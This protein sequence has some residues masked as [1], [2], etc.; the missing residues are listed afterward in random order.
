LQGSPLSEEDKRR[1][2]IFYE[3]ESRAV[4]SLAIL[5]ALK[6]R[7]AKVN[8]DDIAYAERIKRGQ[9]ARGYQILLTLVLTLSVAE[10]GLIGTQLLGALSILGGVAE[11]AMSAGILV[12]GIILVIRR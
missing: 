10:I 12:I 2:D 11:I 8:E 7:D 5:R 6:R 4:Q 3:Y 1:V 9:H